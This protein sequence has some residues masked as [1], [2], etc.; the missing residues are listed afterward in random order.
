[1]LFE[2]AY[3]LI[4][5]NSSWGAGVAIRPMSKGP[6][7]RGDKRYSTFSLSV[8]IVGTPSVVTDQWSSE[9]ALVPN[10]TGDLGGGQLIHPILTVP[11]RPGR[12]PT[13]TRVVTAKPDLVVAFLSK[14]AEADRILAPPIGS[15]PLPLHLIMG[16]RTIDWSL[17]GFMVADY[18]GNLT[19]GQRFHAI[20]QSD[21]TTTGITVP[22]HVIRADLMKSTLAVRFDGLTDSAFRFLEQS[23]VQLNQG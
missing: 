17:S 7:R 12:L 3:R 6:V 19:R 18:R 5:P 11:G 16:Y 8:E 10:Y 20:L 13:T 4:Q 22:C 21:R 15:A 23:V 2:V 1:M 9:G 14:G